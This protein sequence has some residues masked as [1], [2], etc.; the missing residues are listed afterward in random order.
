MVQ[1]P[2]RSSGRPLACTSWPMRLL[3]ACHWLNVNEPFSSSSSGSCHKIIIVLCPDGMES[4]KELNHASLPPA[5][6]VTGS[7]LNDHMDSRL[8]T[9]C[10]AVEAANVA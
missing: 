9:S 10:P 6:N 4:K 7:G 3:A 5:A 1:I 2:L 8:P